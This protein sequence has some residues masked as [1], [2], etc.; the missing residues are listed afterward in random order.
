MTGDFWTVETHNRW[1]TELGEE[2][3]SKKVRDIARETLNAAEEFQT[4]Y[5]FD[6]YSFV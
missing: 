2:D 6:K 5:G 1:E 3:D 4:I